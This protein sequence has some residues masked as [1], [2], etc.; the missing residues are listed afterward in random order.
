MAFRSI[1]HLHRLPPGAEVK[2]DAPPPFLED[3]KQLLSSISPEMAGMDPHRFHNSIS[4]GIQEYMEAMSFLHYLKHGTILTF[5]EAREH[6]PADIPLTLEDYCGGIFDLSGELMRLAVM[7]LAK[8]RSLGGKVKVLED[9]REL[10]VLF[11]RLDPG[12]GG[13][14]ARDWERKLEVMKQSV[15]KVEGMVYGIVVRGNER[16]EGWIGDGPGDGDAD[17]MDME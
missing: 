16:P 15:E 8:D 6:L 11:E 7:Q 13:R 10:R 5:A 12:S 2:D 14:S 4:P 1:F 9:L 17:R 3:I